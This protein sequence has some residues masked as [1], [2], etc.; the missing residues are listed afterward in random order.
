MPLAGWFKYKYLQRSAIA[1]NI[2]AE[3][4]IFASQLRG[5]VPQDWLPNMEIKWVQKESRDD[6]FREKRPVIR[7]RPVRNQDSNFV[8]GVHAFFGRSIFPSTSQ[9]IPSA[10]REAAALQI[11]RKLIRQRRP[12]LKRVLDDEVIEPVVCAQPSVLQYLDRYD[13][14]D[15]RGYF[16]GS[17]LREVHAIATEAKYLPARQTIERDIEE[18]LGH[19]ELFLTEYNRTQQ[20]AQNPDERMVPIPPELWSNHGAITN[21][22]FLLIAAPRNAQANNFRVF[23][24]RARERAHAGVERLYVFGTR[25]EKTFAR[26][27]IEAISRQV[28]EMKLA[29]TFKTEFDYRGDLGGIGALFILNSD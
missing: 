8:R 21:Y 18:I 22:G 23:V 29:A 10:L 25:K 2:S 13:R 26:S 7:M 24:N 16:T 6:F 3:V 4:N 1:A 9:I 14:L 19:N 17:F 5:E 12:S 15:R 20:T 28:P 11:T 27:A